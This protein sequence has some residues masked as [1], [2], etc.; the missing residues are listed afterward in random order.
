MG[1]VL[2]K[3]ELLILF[4]SNNGDGIK[5]ISQQELNQILEGYVA[6]GMLDL[7][8]LTVHNFIVKGLCVQVAA[9]AFVT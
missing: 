3:H 6:V 4:C 9:R 8:C 2:Y 1:I 7:F 5:T